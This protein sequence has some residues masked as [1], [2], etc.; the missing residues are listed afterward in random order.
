MQHCAQCSRT[1]STSAQKLITALELPWPLVQPFLDGQSRTQ[2]QKVN[3]RRNRGSYEQTRAFH[4]SSSSVIEL[5]FTEK[6]ILQKQPCH[7][8]TSTRTIQ[9]KK[10]QP[11]QRHLST[12]SK[13]AREVAPAS[14]KHEL[15]TNNV[16]TG[17]PAKQDTAVKQ[18]TSSSQAT[19][20][21]N[22]PST[23]THTEASQ[24]QQA[25]N[26]KETTSSKLRF[27]TDDV[28]VDPSS[29]QRAKQKA[30]DII[31]TLLAYP[32]LYDPIRRPRHPVVLCHGL[33]GFDTWGLELLPALKWVYVL[34]HWYLHLLL[35]SLPPFH[36]VHYW[37]DV[38]QVLKGIVGIDPIVGVPG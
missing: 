25:K 21:L 24:G 33:Y 9:S 5:A 31:N 11:E 38:L 26:T 34:M 3:A 10:H 30:P 22:S 32:T 20:S 6:T 7:A 35:S 14:S 19:P 13:N 17:S 29:D 36:R 18:Q 27:L 28:I 8:S 37:A 1:A 15:T 16:E 12:S 4:G 23:A 2:R